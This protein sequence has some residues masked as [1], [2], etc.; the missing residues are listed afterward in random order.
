MLFVQDVCH[1]KKLPAGCEPLS[2]K[3]RPEFMPRAQ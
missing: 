1:A 2:E 3:S